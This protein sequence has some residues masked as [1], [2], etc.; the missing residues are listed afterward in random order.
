MVTTDVKSSA[1][2]SMMK[3]IQY[4]FCTS[5]NAPLKKPSEIQEMTMP[6]TPPAMPSAAASASSWRT[7]RPRLAP[8]ALR[9]ATSFS[10]C[11][12]RAS[13]M[14]ATLA[15]ATS[16]TPVTIAMSSIIIMVIC[17]GRLSL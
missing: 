17:G 9:M 5:T 8:S 14:L 15:H 4:G 16:S 12:P 7:T 13:R 11:T 2:T 10:R 6:T 1:G 3:T